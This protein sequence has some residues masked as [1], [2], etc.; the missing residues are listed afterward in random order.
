MYR[1]SRRGEIGRRKYL[2]KVFHEH[3]NSATFGQ[4]VEETLM[5]GYTVVAALFAGMGLGLIALG[6]LLPIVPCLARFVRV[7]MC[8]GG[9]T[10][11]IL[12]IWFITKARP[13]LL[14]MSDSAAHV[15]GWAAISACTLTALLNV[16]YS[17][18]YTLTREPIVAAAIGVSPRVREWMHGRSL[19]PSPLEQTTELNQ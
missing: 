3:I 18:L 6:L 2:A 8:L 10:S 7:S 17:V 15:I 9:S 19:P 4:L 5:Q 13:L 1:A 11:V 14:A 16:V 12:G